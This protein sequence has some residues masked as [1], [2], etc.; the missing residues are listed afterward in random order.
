MC[1]LMRIHRAASAGLL[2]I[3][4]G[5]CGSDD[6][7][8]AAAPTPVPSEFGTYVIGD[9]L[10]FF[11]PAAVV[12]TPLALFRLTFGRRGGVQ[13]AAEAPDGL[14][15]TSGG[16]EYAVGAVRAHTQHDRSLTLDV[17]TDAGPGRIELT[18]RTDR[19]LE[20]RFIPPDPEKVTQFSDVYTLTD[21]ELIY[22]LTGRLTDSPPINVPLGLPPVDELRPREVGSLDR[23]GETI[24]MYVR[25]TY[26]L[27]APFHQSSNGYGLAVAGSTPGTYDIGQ[28]DP[29]V[30]RFRFETGTTEESRMLDY[31]LFAGPRHADI[32]DE[33]TAL[34]GRPFVPPEWA[35]KHWRW[36]DELHR[37]TPVE[38]DGV[39]LNPELADDLTMYAALDIPVGVYMIDRPWSDGSFGFNTFAWDLMRF[40]DVDGMFR[41]FK[42]R[43]YR[44]VLWSAALAAGDRPGDNGTEAK[45]LGYLA[46]GVTTQPDAQVI[47]LTNPEAREWW[48]AKHVDFL[49]RY[50]ISGIKLDRGEEY[51]PSEPTQIY[52]DGRT[53]REVHNEY[54]V[55]NLRLY[56][57]ILQEARG[58]GDFVVKARAAY[59]GAQQYGITWGGDIPGSLNLGTGP[60]TDLGLRT[61]II[62]L[63]RAAFLGFAFW[64]TDTGGYYQF[65]QRD[66]FARWLEFSAFCPLMEIGGGG[67]HAPWDMPTE[68]HYDDE[69]IAIY[70]RYTRLHHDLIPYTM[71]YAELAAR[72]GMPIARPLV[73]AYA[74]D[75]AVRDRWDEYLYGDDLLVAPLWRDGD[76]MR[77]VYLPAGAWEDFWDRSRRFDGPATVT[78]DAPLDRIP[79]FVRAGADIPGRP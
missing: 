73:F 72:T 53:G 21:G 22:G 42:D 7:Q 11:S 40:P 78:A 29:A 44:V 61:A 25:A 41:I 23:R 33:Y 63:Q 67:T 26:G 18:W 50:D 60:G 70:R 43:G 69:M 65:K 55:L 3:L 47:D 8:R 30:L 34:T 66:V 1:R 56:H 13:L 39:P 4:I 76:R 16:S 20:V 37:G 71:R 49:R 24:D 64:G 28:S 38:V 5:A 77:E 79:V 27:Y 75:A 19:T 6:D 52:A 59:S 54:P 31:F 74:D 57:D 36:R 62:A 15:F 17:D 2:L 58:A 45:A 10:G 14:R 68:P 48:K 9:V 35:F 32:L 12:S 51:V 46:P